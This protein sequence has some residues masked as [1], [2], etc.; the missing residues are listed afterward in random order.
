[1]VGIYDNASPCIGCLFFESVVYCTNVGIVEINVFC[2]FC[3]NNIT[4]VYDSL[5]NYL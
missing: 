5:I 4:A 3:S 1:M 2:D